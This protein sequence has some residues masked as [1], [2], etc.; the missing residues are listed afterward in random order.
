MSATPLIS[1]DQLAEQLGDADL[2]IFDTS[3]QL[4]HRED[5]FGYIPVSGRD[6]WEKA[7]IPGAGFLD[8]FEE[9]SD[10]SRGIPFMMPEAQVF[11]DIMAS[12]GVGDDSHVVLYN[13]GIPMWSTRVWWMLKSIGFDQVQVLDGGIAKWRAEGRAL[14]S[15]APDFPAATL[16]A[17]ARPEMW[18]DKDDMLAQIEHTTSV[19]LNALSPEVY[20]GEKNQ[21][22]RAGHLP[23]TYNVFYGHLLDAESGEFLKPESLK[24]LF[25]DSGALDAEHVIT[26][27]GGGISATMDCLALELCGQ[28]NVAVYDGSM[29]EWVKDPDLPLSLG[30]AP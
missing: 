7:H 4:K 19:C 27:C 12:H 30:A 14:T 5:G 13:D 9:L 20:S 1:T 29:S 2:R 21:Y 23:G 25:E 17:K 24:S 15:E 11:A 3:I 28:T 10:T 22:G 8:V 6:D 16:T 26:Y 18:A